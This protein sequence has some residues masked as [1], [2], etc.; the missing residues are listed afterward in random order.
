M[1]RAKGRAGQGRK[2]KPPAA[3]P[4]RGSSRT[5]LRASADRS[6]DRR[7]ADRGARSARHDHRQ[8]V[9][10]AHARHLC[11][12]ARSDHLGADVLHRRRRRGDAADRLSLQMA[13][14]TAAPADRHHRL[15]R[16]LGVVRH[17]VEPG[18][19]GGVPPGPR[20]VRRA[21]GAVEPGDPARCLSAQ[22]ARPGVGD[23]RH[24]HHGGAGDRPRARR[25]PHRE[26]FLA[27]GVLHQRA[28]RHFC[29]VDGHRLSA[30]TSDQGHED[31]LG[32]HGT[33]GA[34][35]RRAA[36]RPRPGPV[37]RLV[38]LPRHRRPAPSSPPSP[39]PRFSC[40]AGT[41][42]TTSSTCRCCGTAIL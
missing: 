36:I 13:R 10:P 39:P 32:G 4:A 25:L 42:A 29:P 19:H 26:L 16:V 18:E 28:A 17:V 30:E 12:H 3:P 41:R 24:G 22:S 33:P 20:R 8:R 38:Q 6:R 5:A 35:R 40:E 7:G 15:R 27:H 2:G 21:A 14:A 1:S 34:R 11:R 37:A 23:L 31:R 9:D